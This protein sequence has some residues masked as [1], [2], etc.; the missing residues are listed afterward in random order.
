M[1]VSRNCWKAFGDDQSFFCLQCWRGI[2]LFVSGLRVGRVAFLLAL[3]LRRLSEISKRSRAI[4]EL[5]ERKLR[6]LQCGVTQENP[7]VGV[8]P[9]TGPLFGLIGSSSGR[10]A[11]R[12][13]RLPLSEGVDIVMSAILQALGPLL[14]LSS[15]STPSYETINPPL[16]QVQAVRFALPFPAPLPMNGPSSPTFSSTPRSSILPSAFVSLAVCNTIGIRRRSF[17]ADIVQNKC[18]CLFYHP[19]SP[20]YKFIKQNSSSSWWD[21][22]GI[23]DRSSLTRATRK[24]GH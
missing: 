10:R 19:Q 15:D 24:S 4:L 13:G 16:P 18:V 23:F 20:G 2:V 17:F 22:L 12:S 3:Q 7:H 9:L 8:L 14:T 11:G 21:K 1:R 5:V 6:G